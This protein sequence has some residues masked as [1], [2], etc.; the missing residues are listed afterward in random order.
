VVTYLSENVHGDTSGV[1][2]SCRQVQ[3][4][5]EV[6]IRGGLSGGKNIWT[7]C[8]TCPVVR[9]RVKKFDGGTPQRAHALHGAGQM[10]R[11]FSRSAMQELVLPSER[12]TTPALLQQR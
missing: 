1:D 7:K 5:D 9:M 10:H 4:E 3:R 11:T 12:E 6:A 2:E 8:T